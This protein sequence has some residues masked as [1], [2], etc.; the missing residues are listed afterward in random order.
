V[1]L[2][3]DIHIIVVGGDESC[4]DSEISRLNAAGG[5]PL[6]VSDDTVVLI[7]QAVQAWEVTGGSD[8]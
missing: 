7:T 4:P 3:A 8:A 5:V 1:P 6:S 2:G